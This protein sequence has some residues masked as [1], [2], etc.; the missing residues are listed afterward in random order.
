MHMFFKPT[1][2]KIEKW[3]QKGNIAKLDKIMSGNNVELR[4]TAIK[5]IGK[6]GNIDTINFLSSYARHPEAE[7]RKLVAEAMGESGE[8][9]NI[10]FLRKLVKDD[11]NQEVREAARN[12]IAKINKALEH[13]Q[14]EQQ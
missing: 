1:A 11:D 5:A 2:N 4:N 14:E 3:A 8:E 13:A 10:E 9:R 6:C 7:V 12:A